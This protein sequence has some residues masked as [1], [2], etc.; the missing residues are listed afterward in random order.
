[1]FE[2]R[3]SGIPNESGYFK[4]LPDVLLTIDFPHLFILL[5]SP[6]LFMLL[7]KYHMKIRTNLMK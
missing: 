3:L 1:M 6:F 7:L 2:Y 5:R 4:F